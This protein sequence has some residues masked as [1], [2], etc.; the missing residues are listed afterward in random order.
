MALDPYC[1][2]FTSV[3]RKARSALIYSAVIVW[4]GSTLAS[5][6]CT[7]GD[8]YEVALSSL[9]EAERAFSSASAQLGTRDAFID[10]LADDAVIFRPGPVNA[11]SY[12][13][14]QPLEPG[15]L[16]W[17]PVFADV[18]AAG[19]LGFTTGPWEFRREPTD[20]E[21]IAHG[22]YFSIWMKQADGSWKV[23][24]DHGTVSPAPSAKELLHTPVR[25][26]GEPAVGSPTDA[27]VL[28][29][30]LLK[31]DRDFATSSQVVGVSKSLTTFVGTGV[32][33]LR[34]GQQPSSGVD[35][36]RRLHSESPGTLTWEPLGGGVSSSGDVGYTF[37]EYSI[38]APTSPVPEE[39]GNYLR[40]WRRQQDGN[41][42][43]VVDLMTPLP[44]ATGG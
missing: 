32:R 25:V 6:S 22:Q 37:G 42:M 21:A 34:N 43:I 23:V 20:A 12:L 5:Y 4:G 39:K 31:Q 3:K 2:I 35:A 17:E 10:N 44:S 36:M 13:Q 18:G 28:R 24:V 7:G 41:W 19:D 38:A 29:E 8:D 11:Q 27:A 1:L 26:T 9:V 14:Q 40:A 33:V 16:S 15:L 30:S